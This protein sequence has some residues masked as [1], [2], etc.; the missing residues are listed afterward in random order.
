M[1]RSPTAPASIELL[2]L[3]VDGV[4]TDG[5]LWF[6][7]AGESLKVFHVHD[8]LGIKQAAAAGVRIAVISGRRHHAV[9]ARMDELG[10]ALVRQGVPDK[11]EALRTLLADTGIAA[12]NTA[13]IVDD[14]S[15]VPLMKAVGLSVAVADAHPTAIAAADRVTRLTGG[16]GA[17][18]EIC[19]LLVAARGRNP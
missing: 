13:C 7:A 17:V 11:V 5:R 1:S 12:A 18:R 3:D 19:D 10:V 14:S 8:G 4:L 6:G 9:D 15:D 16:R 2:V